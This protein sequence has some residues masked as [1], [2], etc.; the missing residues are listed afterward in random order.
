MDTLENI[1]TFKSDDVADGLASAWTSVYKLS[2]GEKHYSIFAKMSQMFKNVRYLYKMFGTTD[3]SAIGNGTCTGATRTG[4]YVSFSSLCANKSTTYLSLE[5]I[6]G[7]R[8]PI[9]PDQ[10]CFTI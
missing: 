1:V 6:N 4:G 3:I 10:S 9:S 5:L 7:V 2:S 8:D